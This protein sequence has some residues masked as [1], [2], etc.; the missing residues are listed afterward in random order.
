[1]VLSLV[2]F[3]ARFKFGRLKFGYASAASSVFLK[4]FI[5]A[6]RLGLMNSVSTESFFNSSILTWF[7]SRLCSFRYTN[8]YDSTILSARLLKSL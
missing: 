8:S 6:F 1:M 2:K 4:I 5:L 7:K 3:S